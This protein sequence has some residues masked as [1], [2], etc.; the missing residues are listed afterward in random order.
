ML[1]MMTDEG[2]SSPELAVWSWVESTW[3]FELQ[4]EKLGFVDKVAMTLFVRLDRVSRGEQRRTPFVALSC[5]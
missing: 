3:I 5:T 2:K 1:L 4:L